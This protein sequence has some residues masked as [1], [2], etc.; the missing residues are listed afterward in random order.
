MQGIHQRRDRSQIYVVLRV[1]DL[2]GPE[3]G[4]KIYVD[5]EKLRQDA[6]LQFTSE[7]WSVVPA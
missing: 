7:Q 1:F 3:I 6:S 2:E 4:M 5:P